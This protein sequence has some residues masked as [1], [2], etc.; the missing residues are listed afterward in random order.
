MNEDVPYNDEFNEMESTSEEEDDDETD[1]PKVCYIN[2][3]FLSF[4]CHSKIARYRKTI[5]K[6][7]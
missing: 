4:N 2:C 5:E 1:E 6:N 7:P 3:V